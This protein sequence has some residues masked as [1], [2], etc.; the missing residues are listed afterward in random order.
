MRGL[1]GRVRQSETS[2][3]DAE[4]AALDLVARFC[5]PRQGVLAG[6][7]IWQDRRFLAASMPVLEGFLHFRMVDVTSLKIL[8]RAWLGERGVF[9][10]DKAHTAMA[11][12]RAS[13]E[14]LG[15]YKKLF[16]IG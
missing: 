4:R 12:V 13:I 14:E 15:F 9:R 8:A 3:G 1:L 10:K 6:N 16:G 2:L 7:S 5:G 11:D